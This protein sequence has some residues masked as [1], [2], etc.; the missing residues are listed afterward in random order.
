MI[1][2]GP[3]DRLQVQAPNTVS[4]RVLYGLAY[5]CLSL[6]TVAITLDPPTERVSSTRRAR[7]WL[8]LGMSCWLSH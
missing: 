1:T 6:V 4:S 2:A 7:L 3:P 5:L 8:Q